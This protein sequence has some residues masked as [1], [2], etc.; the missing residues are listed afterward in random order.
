MAISG[1]IVYKASIKVRRS[2]IMSGVRVLSIKINILGENLEE[3][4]LA[5]TEFL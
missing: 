1:T 4:K 3:R 5:Q 2:V